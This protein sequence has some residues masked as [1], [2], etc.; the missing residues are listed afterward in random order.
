M[1]GLALV[2]QPGA[3][4]IDIAN[5]FYKR[6]EQLK[7]ELPKDF[8][9]NIALD[10]TKFVKKAVNEVAETLLIAILLVILIIFLFFGIGL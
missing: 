1:I 9:I 2:P 6:F 5:E 8:S 7:K 3:N 10:N 4:Y